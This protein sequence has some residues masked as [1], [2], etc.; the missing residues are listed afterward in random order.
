MFTAGG[1]I[2]RFLA[3]QEDALRTGERALRRGEDA[4][5]PTRVATR[6]LRSALRVFEDFVDAAAA[7]RLDAEL[8]WF[9]GLL[10]EVRDLDVQRARL[11]Q[12]VSELPDELV[13]GPVL[14]RI[15]QYIGEERAV[16]AAALRT[17]MHGPRYAELLRSVAAWAE[18]PP[19]T[20][21]A[22][23][24]PEVLEAAVVA[25]A[26]K[27]TRSVRRGLRAG[28]EEELHRA[29]KA[30][31]RA[32]YAAELAQGALGGGVGK[33][34]RRYQRLQDVLGEHQDSVVTADLLRSIALSTSGV[35]G[36]NGFTFGLLHAAEQRRAERS[37]AEAEAWASK[38]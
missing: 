26:E 23:E 28:D 32:R 16:R 2:Q 14:A 8:A 11:V 13:L 10:G 19:F 15:E 36:E 24:P 5:H 21:Q 34:L 37:R 1:T 29:R 31:K 6:R 17:A 12:A 3:E 38:R 18:S 22:A 25:A 7:R 4:I 27:V 33:R 35:P 30:G 9:A 20:R